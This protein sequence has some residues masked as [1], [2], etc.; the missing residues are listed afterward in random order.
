MCE[1]E[2]VYAPLVWT[3]RKSA[4][5][6]KEETYKQREN[7]RILKPRLTCYDQLVVS[8]LKEIKGSSK[9]AY[10]NEKSNK[11]EEAGKNGRILMYGFRCSLSIPMRTL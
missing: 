8:F 6:E 2:K 4:G 9:S 7:G 11:V 3:Y 5:K 10:V 1:N